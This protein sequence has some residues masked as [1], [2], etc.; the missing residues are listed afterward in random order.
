M[1]PLKIDSPTTIR[2]FTYYDRCA[3]RLTPAEL[4]SV[5]LR[6]SVTI[7]ATPLSRSQNYKYSYPKEFYGYG[8]AF[9]KN[10]L[11]KEFPIN[12]VSQYIWDYW[13]QH[14]TIA[15]QLASI[16]QKLA[17][18]GK[19]S[20]DFQEFVLPQGDSGDGNNLPASRLK[21]Q[22]LTE[23]LTLEESGGANDLLDPNN[24][25]NSFNHPWDLLRFKFSE[26]TVFSVAIESW[27]AGPTSGGSS[28]N[29]PAED[30]LYDPANP[31]GN[32]PTPSGTN[33]DPENPYGP[34]S[35][36]S[37][38]RDDTLDPSDFSNAPD[39]PLP[40][41]GECLRIFGVVQVAGL[42][43]APREIDLSFGPYPSGFSVSWVQTGQDSATPPRAFYNVEVKGVGGVLVD[44]PFTGDY[45]RS[46]TFERVQCDPAP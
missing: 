14:L 10:T 7:L 13:N 22:T 34:E 37:S 16:F 39:P 6:V 17:D 28:A 26:Y 11:I 31:S 19:V 32:S 42:D 38:P 46:A 25:V 1:I 27:E 30:P 35:P 33:R 5:R 44:I 12:Y 23:G 24:Y 8:Q 2:D 41:G 29:S 40:G 4:R 43:E 15:H 18:F 20:I 45:L 3:I 21:Q 9:S 36:D